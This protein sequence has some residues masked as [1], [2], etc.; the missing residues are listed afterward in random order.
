MV[1]SAFLSSRPVKYCLLV[2]RSPFVWNFHNNGRGYCAW[3]WSTGSFSIVD[4]QIHLLLAFQ[5]F[6]RFGRSPEKEV[7]ANL[8]LVEVS[9]GTYYIETL[10][11]ICH[12]RVQKKTWQLL[13]FW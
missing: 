9:Y 4:K 7:I 8:L 10:S 3:Y 11:I 6:P 1:G 5:R 2:D 13:N 12:R